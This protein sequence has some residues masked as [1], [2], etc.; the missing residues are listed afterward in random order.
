MRRSH[1]PRPQAPRREVGHPAGTNCFVSRFS[2]S[3][4][5]T[6][7][8]RRLCWGR[9][10][11]ASGPGVHVSERPEPEASPDLHGDRETDPREPG[12]ESDPRGPGDSAT[13][14]RA[15]RAWVGASPFRRPRRSENGRR[16]RLPGRAT[17]ALE[18]D[19]R[20]RRAKHR[21]CH[22]GVD[23]HCGVPFIGSVSSVSPG[24]LATTCAADSSS[25]ASTMTS[26][27]SAVA[28][29]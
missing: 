1:R 28:L 14:A 6:H 2:P 26:F 9:R 11:F 25:G 29:R 21:R 13:Q 8:G 7:L 16:N 24:E 23:I 27:G 10:Q 12:V 22:R 5:S 17:A 19:L 18:A 15:M 20:R 4:G 3:P